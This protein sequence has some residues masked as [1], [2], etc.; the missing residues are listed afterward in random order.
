LL[1]VARARKIEREIV[2]CSRV[3]HVRGVGTRDKYTPIAAE[4]RGRVHC[5]LLA[6]LGDNV[7]RQKER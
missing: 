2:R 1:P 7:G 3:R 4:D 6:S 5:P